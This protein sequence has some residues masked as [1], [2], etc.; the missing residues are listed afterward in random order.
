M[1]VNGRARSGK[2]KEFKNG[3][4]MQNMKAS[5]KIIKHMA[6]ENFFM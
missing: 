1:K 3:L 4:I 5:G 2:G 6:K